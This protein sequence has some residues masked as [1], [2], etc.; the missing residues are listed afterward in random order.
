MINNK[1]NLFSISSGGGFVFSVGF[2]GP[3]SKKKKKMTNITPTLTV[4]KLFGI[5][6]GKRDGQAKRELKFHQK[7]NFKVY[8]GQKIRL[9]TC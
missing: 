5:N 1:S 9:R 7:T 8:T 2:A 4:I 3:G 6:V